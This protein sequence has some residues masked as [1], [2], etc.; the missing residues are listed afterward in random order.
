VRR[1]NGLASRK[2]RPKK[3]AFSSLARIGQ[4]TPFVQCPTHCRFFQRRNAPR[5]AMPYAT[6]G[7]APPPAPA[8]VF[9]FLDVPN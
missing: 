6:R 7:V 8:R 1:S 3:S 2:N 4:I 5:T 9:P